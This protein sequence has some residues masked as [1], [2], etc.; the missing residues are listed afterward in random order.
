MHNASVVGAATDG[1]DL[2]V[3]CLEGNAAFHNLASGVWVRVWDRVQA[4][5]NRLSGIKV[6]YK[7]AS[8]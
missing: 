2:C 7:I 1:D 8:V 6:G 5:A 4:R 3:C